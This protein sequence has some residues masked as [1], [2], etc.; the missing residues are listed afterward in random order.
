MRYVPDSPTIE[1]LR[2]ARI[3]P[4]P[5][6]RTAPTLALGNE[7]GTGVP[8]RYGADTATGVALQLLR[9][10]DAAALLSGLEAVTTHSFSGDR[11]LA[12]WALCSPDEA[13]A[14]ARLLVAAARAA[15]FGVAHAEEAA[16]IAC[17]FRAYPEESGI[18]D[19]A[20]LYTDL[21][22]KVRQLLDRPKDFDLYWIGEYSDVLQA[23]N[24]LG[25]GAVQIENDPSLDLSLIHTPL[26]LHDLT[27]LTAAACSRLLTVRSE[28]TYV[29]EY[30]RES[31][32]PFP[33]GHPLPRI[34]LR[35]LAQRLNLFERA[36]GRW[37]AEPLDVPVP[38]LFLDAGQGRPAPSTIAAATVIDEVVSYLQ[39]AA[40]RTELH[41][42]PR[43]VK[44]AG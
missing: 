31:W 8:P 14:R 2:H 13:L 4:V 5:P 40:R 21:L 43:M 29:L 26:R 25:S 34:D 7:P 23:N 36:P 18:E 16:Q 9:S 38:R 10:P 1:A 42:T 35:P 20:A 41:W 27:R 12:M 22:P 44:G 37:Q 28:N 39:D 15:E 17:F 11:L 3:G 32:V 30:R 6:G 24:L 19:A 33:E